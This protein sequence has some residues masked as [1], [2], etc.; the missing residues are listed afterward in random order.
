M[1]LCPLSF[2]CRACCVGSVEEEEDRERGGRRGFLAV[3][4]AAA[5]VL[6]FVLNCDSLML[7]HV[8]KI[9][10]AHSNTDWREKVRAFFVAG[11]RTPLSFWSGIHY[12]TQSELL[13][14]R[15]SKNLENANMRLK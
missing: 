15:N 3:N 6:S 14:L 1:L 10:L 11:R 5:V 13:I 12:T 2:C 8:H 9:S 4:V 7:R